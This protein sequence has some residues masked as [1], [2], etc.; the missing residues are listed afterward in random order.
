MWKVRSLETKKRSGVCAEDEPLLIFVKL[1]GSYG[2]RNISWGESELAIAVR[3]DCRTP[4]T[5]CGERLL[6]SSATRSGGAFNQRNEIRSAMA[7]GD[8]IQG[9]SEK[10]FATRLLCAVSEAAR[11]VVTVS[12]I[13]GS[14]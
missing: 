14:E 8:D 3:F 10:T 2:A 11:F 4:G 5:F 6:F 1:N 7:V 12:V 9:G 13:A